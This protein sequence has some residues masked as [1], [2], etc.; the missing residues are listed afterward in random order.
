MDPAAAAAP[1]PWRF[2]TY[3]LRAGAVHFDHPNQ[4]GVSEQTGLGAETARVTR[5]RKP[6][7][8][9]SRVR[10]PRLL[11]RRRAQTSASEK[12][13]FRRDN[14]RPPRDFISAPRVHGDGDFPDAVRSS[15]AA[16]SE[17]R[18][19]FGAALL[20]DMD[21]GFSRVFSVDEHVLT[22]PFVADALDS[23][24]SPG[25]EASLDQTI[26]LVISYRHATAKQGRILN[27]PPD[28]WPEIHADVVLLCRRA[29][30]SSFRLWTDQILSS[31]KPQAL[32]RWVS[33]G[34]F[35]YMVYPVYYVLAPDPHADLRR[36]W[37]SIEHLA[38]CFGQGLIHA[39]DMLAEDRL[40]HEWVPT[41][42]DVEGDGRKLTWVTGMKNEMYLVI[43][44]VC[45][46][47]MCGL[48][49]GKALSW[50]MDGQDI[51][52]WASTITG[53]LTNPDLAHTFECDDCKRPVGYSSHAR[54]M[55]L[56]SSGSRILLNG[57]GPVAMDSDT[58][59]RP[60]VPA[61]ILQIDNK[62][63]DGVREWLPE[64]CLWGLEDNRWNKKAV[65]KHCKAIA[66][67]KGSGDRSIG[68]LQYEYKQGAGVIVAY[69][70]VGIVG[71]GGVLGHGRV[72]WSKRFWPVDPV[73][74]WRTFRQLHGDVQ[75]E[76]ALFDL[77]ILVG[78]SA[79]IDYTDIS[80]SSVVRS[81]KL[82]KVKW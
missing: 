30:C 2:S 81:L 37:I 6:Y 12:V 24:P 26:S 4:L 73:E 19:F 15:R 21:D 40:P 3:T 28:R 71:Q 56:L 61:L 18:R 23:S 64:S 33:S 5:F 76:E 29:G 67:S 53:S 44:R 38:A 66:I 69:L 9:P 65:M 10:V 60:N 58:H 35:P 13:C 42:V 50:P 46:I 79:G 11:R 8:Y 68:V 47:I 31:R 16:L 27:L 54:H 1:D 41:Y 48:L 49:R 25:G 63:W 32:L 57:S 75:N 51:I 62:S 78:A 20:A 14:R 45:G 52:E 77:A 43:R 36:M 72:G 39:G 34:V 7:V 74:M 55:G 17:A 59:P 22:L 82:S 80:E 70:L